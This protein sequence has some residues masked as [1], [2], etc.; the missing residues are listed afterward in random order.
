M[1]F[2]LIFLLFFSSVRATELRIVSTSPVI[3]DFIHFFKKQDQ[4]LAVSNYCKNKSSL[5]TIGSAYSLDFEKILKF[6]KGHVFLESINDVR[7]IDSLK[8]LGIK[9]TELKFLR[10]SDIRKSAYAIASVLEADTKSLDLLFKKLKQRKSSPKRVLL[11]LDETIKDDVIT[12]VRAVSIHSFYSDLLK[13][14]GGIN[15]LVNNKIS[16]P[17]LDIEKILKLKPEIIVRISEKPLE[18]N[19]QKAWESSLFKDNFYVMSDRSYIIP[20]PEV[21]RIYQKMSEILDGN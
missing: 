16:Y 9:Y 13:L 19:T 8:K 2:L 17:I 7:T 12:S 14:A 11:I 6:K 3:T 4:L 10:L 1:R 20:G 5:P 18:E 21:S 15:P